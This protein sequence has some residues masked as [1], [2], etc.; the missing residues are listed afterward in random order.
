M[1]DDR[2]RLKA[3]FDDKASAG[4]RR[5]GKTL[6]DLKPSNGMAAATKWMADFRGAADKAN[7]AV[8]PIS[9]SLTA[10]GIG[11]LAASLSMGE[12][13]RQFKGL[14]DSTLNLRELSRQ[15][16]ISM[17][18][19]RQL[20]YAAG[21]LH[22]DPKA[23]DGALSGFS[24]KML[25]ARRHTGDF[26]TYLLRQNADVAQKI[27][28][29]SPVEALKDTLGYLS[30]I[31]DPQIQQR[32]A[33]LAGLGNLTPMLGKGPDGLAA[34][35]ADAAR[36]VEPLS[37]AMV[38]AADRLNEST[39]RLGQ[40]WENLLNDIGPKVIDPMTGVVDKLDAAFKEGEKLFSRGTPEV[41]PP[42]K[43]DGTAGESTMD[44]LG[45]T[46]RN[47]LR[48]E[49]SGDNEM[50]KDGKWL[51]DNLFGAGE[52][53]ASERPSSQ[54]D[55]TP[56]NALPARELFERVREGSKS[57]IIAG[58]RELAQQQELDPK[59]DGAGGVGAPSMRYGRN[60]ASGGYRRGGHSGGGRGYADT[61]EGAGRAIKGDIAERAATY[62]D[63]LVE[64]KGWTPEGASILIGNG[65]RES[66][67]NPGT[68]PG[69]PNTPGG[70]HYMFQWNNGKNGDTVNGRR[71]KFERWARDNGRSVL[72]PYANLDFADEERKRRSGLEA[73]W[74]KQT[75]LHNAGRLGH[76]FEG[77][78][79]QSE[80]ERVQNARDALTAYRRRH[81]GAG[82]PAP[83]AA[84]IS[85]ADVFKARQRLLSGSRD[86]KDRELVD[87]Y[88]AQ[89]NQPQGHAA[90]GW[91]KGPGGPTGDR[92]PAML[93]NGEFV[94]QAKAAGRFLPLLHAINEG[95][96]SHFAQ[97]GQARRG[98]G[99][100]PE[101]R[102]RIASW[103]DFFMRPDGEGGMGA[104]RRTALGSIAMMQGES[105]RN[106]NPAIYNPNDVDGPSGGS[107]QWHDVLR[108]RYA[109][110]LRRFSDL[111]DFATAQHADWKDIGVQ[112]AFFKK[113][114][115]NGMR[116]A[117]DPMRRARTA[118]GTLK[119][120]IA[121]FENPAHHSLEF[122]RRLPN[123]TAMVREG[124]AGLTR[125]NAGPIDP[126]QIDIRHHHNGQT[127]VSARG[128]RGTK[129]GIRSGPTMQP[130]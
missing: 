74:H 71:A 36:E 21:K 53:H 49:F 69:D 46:F 64:K 91:I 23:L 11:G 116:F 109:G 106:L 98:S 108:G 95:R 42:R 99:F 120:G 41:A 43:P 127:R 6:A 62:M 47:T 15:S 115:R 94:V 111:M 7:V 16:R 12:L 1:A 100:T 77:Y 29:E 90:G 4:V 128:G 61:P 37:Q 86:P 52:A 70:S 75:D 80:A 113:E 88:K 114:A 26:Y 48:H 38:K 129:L 28:S 72:D 93:S 85:D 51:W 50:V 55:G 19:L 57:G 9:G 73:Q 97:G 54:G 40:R 67:L 125:G 20:R 104:S 63:Y 130:S 27:T 34:A 35:F 107:V 8:R 92:I 66:R 13:V 112:Q 82:T 65:M 18:D 118:P 31:T 2:L 60:P 5:L 25:D 44:Y 22:V 81:S 17:D 101:G 110:K 124:I 119:E 58:L 30:R 14:A 123:I 45:R 3:E 96:L 121:R 84:A 78:G 103:M 87:R 105:G 79:D 83:S 117:W 126:I 59:H 39:N 89:Q 76:L 10:L 102:A 33:D 68:R 32:V 56:V 122:A 24:D